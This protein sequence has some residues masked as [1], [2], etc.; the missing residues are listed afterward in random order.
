MIVKTGD[1]FIS[2]AFEDEDFRLN[3]IEKMKAAVPEAERDYNPVNK[4]WFIAL[5]EHNKKVIRELA[6]TSGEAT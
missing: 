5:N 6:E 1:F 3:N 2:V 4:F